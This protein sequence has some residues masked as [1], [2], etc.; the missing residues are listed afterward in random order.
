MNYKNKKMLLGPRLFMKII[1]SLV[2]AFFGD[3]A[4]ERAEGLNK[5]Q[6]DVSFFADASR[7]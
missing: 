5:L 1:L 4:T 2:Y 7:P 3:E 6:M